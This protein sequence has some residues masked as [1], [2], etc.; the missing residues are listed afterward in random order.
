MIGDEYQFDRANLGLLK[1]ELDALKDY[2]VGS[3]NSTAN[4]NNNSKLKLAEHFQGELI[5]DGFRAAA[6]DGPLKPREVEAISA[7]AK[8]L[9]MTDEKFQAILDLYKEEEELRQKRIA[10]LFP[11]P[12]GETIKAIDTH[13][14]R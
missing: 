8:Y 6:A 1:Q 5:Y 3:E 9:G 12:Y 10:F 7:V 2:K 4:F 14:G 11:K 13:Y